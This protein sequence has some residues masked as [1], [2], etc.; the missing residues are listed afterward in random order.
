MRASMG[1][2]R[3]K[4]GVNKAKGVRQKLVI[5]DVNLQAKI[6]RGWVRQWIRRS[7]KR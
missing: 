7:G 1:R 3:S 4:R 6:P 5:Y 2:A